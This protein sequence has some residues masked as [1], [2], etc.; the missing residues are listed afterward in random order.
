ME[1]L[2][3]SHPSLP[4]HVPARIKTLLFF[5]FRKFAVFSFPSTSFSWMG[6][7][8]ICISLV[9]NFGAKVSRFMGKYLK[10]VW[11]LNVHA[12]LSSNI[13]QIISFLIDC[14]AGWNWSLWRK[15]YQQTSFCDCQMETLRGTNNKW[16]VRALK[17]KNYSNFSWALKRRL[18]FKAAI[19]FSYKF[20]FSRIILPK[21]I[22]AREQASLLLWKS[23]FCLLLWVKMLLDVT[24]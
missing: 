2:R 11:T 20:R 4:L 13:F 14:C 10:R 15:V 19:N 1:N 22:T 21:K 5:V 12:H 17:C 3:L 8:F 9:W 16:F 18:G 24:V 6:R 7:V 23:V